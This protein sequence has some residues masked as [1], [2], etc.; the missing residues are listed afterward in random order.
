MIVITLHTEASDGEFPAEPADSDESDEE[1]DITEVAP[2]V[3]TESLVEKSKHAG[4]IRSSKEKSART[5]TPEKGSI[6]T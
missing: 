3:T 1:H 2:E 5:K 4:N 6:R